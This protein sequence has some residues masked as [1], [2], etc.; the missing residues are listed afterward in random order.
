MRRIKGEPLSRFEAIR[1]RVARAHHGP[2]SER[3]MLG[4]HDRPE[5]VMEQADCPGK[6]GKNLNIARGSCC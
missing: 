5:Q 1:S 6:N 4:Q 3:P 2:G